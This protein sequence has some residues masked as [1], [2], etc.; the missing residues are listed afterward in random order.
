VACTVPQAKLEFQVEEDEMG[1]TSSTNGEAYILLME[2]P[3]GRRRLGRTMT[4]WMVILK[5]IF[6]W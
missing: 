5:W 4:R 6:E 2:K 3:E 1:E